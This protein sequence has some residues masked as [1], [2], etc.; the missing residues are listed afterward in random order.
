MEINMISANEA[1][2]RVKMYREKQSE[3]GQALTWLEENVQQVIADTAELGGTWVI[4][5][6]PY[7]IQHAVY[8]VLDEL[9]YQAE[10]IHQFQTK[11]SWK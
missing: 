9:G 1:I 7:K 3:M 4:V 8:E 2:D 5:T 10:P 11:I 6:V